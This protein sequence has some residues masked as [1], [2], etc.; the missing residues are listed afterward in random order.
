MKDLYA[1]RNKIRVPVFSILCANKFDLTYIEIFEICANP[2][3]L[4]QYINST[5]FF[6][7][8]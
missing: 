3:N 2:N 8:K 7:G 6:P 4:K 1:Y 5:Y